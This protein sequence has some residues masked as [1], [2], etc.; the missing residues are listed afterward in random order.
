MANLTQTEIAAALA[1]TIEAAPGVSTVLT[2]DRFSQGNEELIPLLVSQN[3]GV[4]RGWVVS[5]TELQDQVDDG[6]CVVVSTLE[7]ALIY[8]HEYL[9]D[10]IGGKTSDQLFK[11]EIEAV[12]EHLN[13]NRGLGLDSRVRHSMLVSESPFDQI[14]YVLNKENRMAHIAVFSLA[15]EVTNTY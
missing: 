3:E 14:D 9:N 8:L 6:T 12:N 4:M 13:A 7:Y 1:S 15:V 2:D 10:S 11:E 5:W